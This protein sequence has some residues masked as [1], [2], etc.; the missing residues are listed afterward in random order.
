MVHKIA[1]TNDSL[2]DHLQELKNVLSTVPKDAKEASMYYLRTVIPAMNAVR[3]DADNLEDL[4]PKSYWPYPT[5]A[6]LLFY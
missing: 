2:Y 1:E 5:Y 6:D 4:T 3:T